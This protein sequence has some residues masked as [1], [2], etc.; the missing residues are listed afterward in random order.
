VHPSGAS[1]ALPAAAVEQ[2]VPARFEEIAR[3][4]AD[5]LAVKAGD[6]GLTYDELNRTANRVA[7]A[8]LDRRPADPEPV[9]MLMEKGGCLVAGELGVLKAGKIFVA[10]DPS[11]PKARLATLLAECQP[12]MVLTSARYEELAITLTGDRRTVLNVETLGREGAAAD[13]GLLL[14]PDTPAYIIYTSGSTAQPKGVLHSHRSLLGQVQRHVNTL[15]IGAEDRVSIMGSMSAGQANT[16]LYGPLLSGASVFLWDL[17]EDGLADLTAWLRREGITYHRSS[18]S[19]F[20]SWTERLGTRDAFP[21]LRLIG[22]GSEPVYRSDFEAYRRLF[23]PPCQFL[24]ALSSTET[25]TIVMNVLDHDSVLDGRLVPVGYPVED[26]EIALLDEAGAQ[27]PDGDVGAIAVRSSG[28]AVGYWRQEELTRARFRPEPAGRDVRTYVMGDVGRWDPGGALVHLGRSDRQ[29]KV[30]GHR[31]ELSEVEGALRE[32]PAVKDAVVV[33]REDPDGR[34]RLVAYVVA[35]GETP[36]TRGALRNAL[37]GQLP[38]YMLPND[39]AFLDALPV[40]PSGK[41]EFRALPPVAPAARSQPAGARPPGMLGA[42]LGTIWEELLGVRGVGPRDDFLDLGGDSLLAIEMLARIEEVCGRIIPPSRLL[43][44]SIT[45][46]RL[47]RIL[48]DE[49]RSGWGEPVTVVQTGGSRLPLFFLHGDFEHGGLYCHSLARA[50]GPDQPFYSVTPHG[51][52]GGPLPWSIEGMA[53]DRLRSIRA[54]QPSGPYRLG[55]FCNGGVIAFEM[56]RQIEQQGASVDVLLLIDSRALNGPPIYRFLDRAAGTVRGGRR[57]TDATRRAL[58]LRLRA[59]VEDFVESARPDAGGRTR[60]LLNRVRAVWRRRPGRP[61]PDTAVDEV[62]EEAALR[63]AYGERLRDYVPGRYDG[64]VA[65]FRSS[66]LERRPPAG[67]TAGWH[68]V[69][70]AVEVHPLPG[71]HQLAVTRY[72]EVLAEK[73]APYL[74]STS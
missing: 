49:Q 11:F 43:E 38:D 24:N 3:R 1:E 9:A 46:E 74:T 32:N 2:S 64:R 22:L 40:A 52:D 70:R 13:P 66:H 5:R 10:L 6:V 12:L 55:G 14:A 28:L 23:A 17:K 61:T 30:H 34:K 20:R 63:S 51:L 7:H 42:Q 19:I 26:V 8:I 37:R 62:S 60:Y 33:D 29:V 15:H 48:L 68:H 65:L 27:V 44:G 73:M 35:K 25:G 72:V 16:Q 4:H 59:H 21:S 18:A 36:P 47:V 53:A 39:V 69:A 50:L 57:A 56:A 67:P 58:F 54:I 41:I 71:N 45:I 31:V